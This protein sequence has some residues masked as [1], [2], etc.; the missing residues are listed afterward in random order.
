MSTYY[1]NVSPVYWGATEN[2]RWYKEV[3]IGGDGEYAPGPITVTTKQRGN[4]SHFPTAVRNTALDTVYNCKSVNNA[5]ITQSILSVTFSISSPVISVSHIVDPM[6]MTIDFL[7]DFIEGE[8]FTGSVTGDTAIIDLVVTIGS[9]DII[10]EAGKSNWVKWSKIGYLDFTVGRD[11]VAGERP[12]DW[13]GWVYQI[14][15]LGDKVVVYGQNGVS[16]LVPRGNAFGLNTIYRIGLKGQQAVTGDDTKH[17]FIDNAGSLW[18]VSDSMKKLD[19]AEYLSNLNS[20]V[21]MSYDALNNLVYICDGVL[22]FVLDVAT[23]SLGECAA[24]IT[25]IGYKSGVQHVVASSTIVTDA[26]EIC[27]DISD[28]GT[29]AGKTIFSLE[30]G[31][32]LTTGL[33]TAVDWRRDKAGSFTQTPWYTVS[34]QGRAFVIAYGREFRFRAKT[35]SYEYLELDYIKVNGVADAY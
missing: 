33:Y 12:L 29:R 11:N 14:K 15:K 1:K 28:L 19:Y 34:A 4:I 25:G 24:N 17:F 30:F 9:P 13:S 21:V 31:T 6:D 27:T 8:F 7:G 32:D 16:F 3:G 22:G 5:G 20:A 10:T 18:K 2:V 35:T 23:E 26:F